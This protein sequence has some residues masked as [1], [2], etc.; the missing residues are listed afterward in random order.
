MNKTCTK[1]TG[2][3][4][5]HLKQIWRI[6]RIT[7]FLIIVAMMQ[8]SAVTFA[9]KVTLSEKNTSLSKVFTKIS[10]QTGYDFWVNG[11]LLRNTRPVTIDVKDAALDDVLKAIFKDQ[12]VTYSVTDKLVTVVNFKKIDVRGKVVDE[13][14]NPLVQASVKIAGNPKVFLTDSKGEFIIR[15][16]EENVLLTVTYVGFTPL[17]VKAKA[18]LGILTLL[19]KDSKLDEVNV[20]AYGTTTRREATGS[21]STIKAKD[22]AGVPSSNIANLLQ[23][24]VAGL[25]VTNI[26]G[27]PG[28]GGIAMTVRGYNS[29]DVEQGRR[30]SNPLWVVDGV[31]LNSF[32]SPV[33]G[34]NLLADL[35]PDMIESIQVLKDASAASLYGSRA[36]NGVVIV[37]TKKGQNDLKASFA[38][39]ASKSYN[40]LPR[41]PTITIGNAERNLRLAAFRNNRIAYL[42][43]VTLRYK[44]PSSYLEVYRNPSTGRRDYFER[45][46]PS[47]EEGMYLQDSLNSFYNNATN[48][49][50]A[51]YETGEVT[52]ANI[53]TYGGAKNMNYGIGIGYYNESGVLKGS[54]FKRMDLNSSLNVSPT[55]KFHVDLRF[56]TTLTDRNRGEKSNFIGASPIVETV[57]GDPFKLSSL[58]P[59][60]GS[61]VWNN[62]LARLQNIKEN[63]RSVRLRTNFKLS[64]DILPSLTASTSLAADYAVHRRN[65][66]TPSYLSES[67][68]SRSVGETGVNL[69]ALNEN[70]L[71]YNKRI[72][73]DHNIN[74]IAGFSYQYDQ[75]EYNGASADNSPSD[76]IYYARPGF[77]LFAQRTIPG[78]LGIPYTETIAFQS[79]QS[80][81]QEKAL[82]SYFGR[83]EYNYKQKYLISASFRR[84]GSSVFGA[85]NKFGTFPSIAAGWSFGEESFIK[86][87]LPSLN[88]G[89]FRASWGRSGMHFSQ[90]YLALGI[91]KAGGLSHENRG[92]LIPEV[93]D[94]LYN[95][96]LSWEETDQID[97]GLDLDLFN[98]RLGITTDYYYRYTDKMLMP[99]RLPGNYNGF[100]A[101]WRNA[102]AV[103]NEGIEL[104]INY[105]IIRKPNLAWKIS[106]N[107]ARNWN[108][109]EKS[110]NGRDVSSQQVITN[111][112]WVIG[113]P[114]SGIY[115]LKSNGFILSQDEVAIYYNA[116]GIS[117]Y[118]GTAPIFYH[119]PGDYKLLDV[120]GDGVLSSTGDAVYIGSALPEFS[121]GFGTE[122]RRNNFELNLL[123][124]YQ[125][126]RHIVNALPL[127]ALKTNESLSLTHPLLMDLRKA[128]FWAQPGDNADYVPIQYDSGAGM[129]NAL[130]D[131]FVEKVN[132]LKLKTIT[133]RYHLPSAWVKRLKIEA[134]Q[135]F[136]SAENVFT[137]TNYSGLDPETVNISSGIDAGT[138]YPLVRRFN[139]GLT[140]KF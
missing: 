51:Y 12:P 109:F 110:N 4:N 56:N 119:K 42:D 102:A 54:G 7:T 39:N 61:A 90:N 97:L 94:G 18:N 26:S 2:V 29:L 67:G 10:K 111:S 30:F 118:F 15:D 65:S 140:L 86:E 108:R 64:Y 27:S 62:V 45:G 114:L 107:G 115:A 79:Y 87:A 95:E 14:G 11:S 33:T 34:T 48:F 74:V 59:G 69:L 125:L 38:V 81:M 63:N 9:Q 50:P 126:G 92:V 60:E 49:F 113:K 66:F 88:F 76:E 131:R 134:I 55:D 91:M 23:G 19:A 13:K 82:L 28:S 123:F 128:R 73:N 3:P 77:P 127:E 72:N 84:D 100:Q 44:Y 68:Y 58:Y 43:P 1:Q 71:T 6:M 16:V 93:A 121:G 96:D 20:V 78:L 75:E 104:L 8:A 70:L 37:T 53:Q 52:N 120:N 40:I 36:A 138:N 57:P 139:C 41:L 5:Q 99:V 24:R 136:A 106:I 32:T 101:Q 47:N 98:N 85:N 105:E 103:S 46:T 89:K 133:F 21:I 122:I 17:E 137:L 130:T 25:D 80:D 22:I 31:P 129:Y 132:W 124:S 35:N 83:V 135:L 116:A 117:N 112:Q